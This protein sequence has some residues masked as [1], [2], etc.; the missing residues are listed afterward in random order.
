[1]RSWRG[2]RH[3]NP[4]ITPERAGGAWRP[5]CLRRGRL[6][7]RLVLGCGPAPGVCPAALLPPAS[8]P[9]A[10]FIKWIFLQTTR[11]SL[12]IKYRNVWWKLFIPCWFDARPR[13][14]G[15]NSHWIKRNASRS[16]AQERRALRGGASQAARAAAAGVSE[17]QQRAPHGGCDAAREKRPGSRGGGGGVAGPPLPASC[18][19]R[20]ALGAL[21]LE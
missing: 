19:V 20:A 3:S 13:R 12:D 9:R 21:R 1:M 16:C 7:P 5:V 11:Q 4:V 17:R 2:A 6:H 8:R 15:V 18:G 14:A 10:V